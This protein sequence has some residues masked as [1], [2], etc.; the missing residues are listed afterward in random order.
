MKCKVISKCS[1]VVETGSIVEVDER[2]FEAARNVL[3]PMDKAEDTET[4]K[5]E[6]RKRKK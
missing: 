1:L 4:P 5:I 6:T 2:Q 3:V